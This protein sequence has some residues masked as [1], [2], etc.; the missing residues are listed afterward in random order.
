M[1]LNQPTN[2]PNVRFSDQTGLEC[3]TCSST[4]IMFLSFSKCKRKGELDIGD[5][6]T[7]TAPPLFSKLDGWC[8]LCLMMLSHDNFSFAYAVCG[9]QYKIDHS[10]AI[11]SINTLCLHGKINC[12]YILGIPS[13]K[14]CIHIFINVDVSINAYWSL[15][16]YNVY[17]CVH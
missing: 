14:M 16:V 1:P 4:S 15:Y 11:I 8:A 13:I 5:L 17:N 10:P 9:P 12:I 7:V 6:I 2:K 3:D